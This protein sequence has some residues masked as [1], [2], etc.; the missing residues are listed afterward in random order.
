MLWCTE[1]SLWAAGGIYPPQH[2]HS[3]PLVKGVVT[4]SESG[5]TDT[6]SVG[7][8]AESLSER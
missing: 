5:G 4:A 6:Q 7:A 8:V 2:P 3:C 1:L